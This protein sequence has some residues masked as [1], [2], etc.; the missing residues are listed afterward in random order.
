M[1]PTVAAIILL[2]CL[3]FSRALD[4]ENCGS[5]IGTYTNVDLSCDMSKSVCELPVDT[6]VSISLD[7]TLEKDVSQVFAVVHGIIM[8]IPV[9]FPLNNAA[10]CTTPD[11]GLTCPLS[12]GGP[13]HYTNTLPVKK[14]YPKLSVKVKWELRDEDGK[15]IACL[16]IPAKIK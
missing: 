4:I 5:E 12:K 16:L 14:S 15:D 9:P 10:A 2:C 8:D 3:S 1:Y 11:S 13:Y 7:F 6:N